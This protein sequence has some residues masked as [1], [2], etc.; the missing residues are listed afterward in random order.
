[1]RMFCVGAATLLL[2]TAC[3]PRLSTG[4]AP[5]QTTAFGDRI[6]V[7]HRSPCCAN[8][9]IGVEDSLTDDALWVRAERD[10]ARLTVPRAS[11]T[12]VDKW[13]KVNP[14]PAGKLYAVSFAAGAGLG[15]LLDVFMWRLSRPDP[16]NYHGRFIIGGAVAGLLAGTVFGALEDARWEAAS[17]PS[18]R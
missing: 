14:P 12:H 1:M 15:L 8:P 18:T 9:I 17:I 4:P 7:W 16:W 11:I 10:Q 13:I 2:T 3:L 6:R 5:T